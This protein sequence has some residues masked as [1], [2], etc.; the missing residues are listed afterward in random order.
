MEQNGT[1]N[2]MEQARSVEI[3]RN[4]KRDLEFVDNL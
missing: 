4:L 1:V 2:R 3:S